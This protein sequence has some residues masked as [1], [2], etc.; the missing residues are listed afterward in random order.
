[1]KRRRAPAV[2]VHVRPLWVLAFLSGTAALLYQSLWMRSLGLV[3]GNTTDA[4]AMV[5]ATFM[6]GLA[7]GSLV[8]A[9]RPAARPLRAYA[10]VELAL[11][12]TALLTWPLLKLLPAAYAGVAW[13]L[14]LEGAADL[15]ARGLLSALVL[16]PPT[17]L[18]GA[19]VP[20][21][22]E[23]LTRAGQGL[24]TV[25]A[26]IY[27]VNTLGAALGVA[28]G[29]FLLVPAL[30]L[31]GT[32]LAA[33]LLNLTVGLAALRWSEKEPA[34]G[35]V[36]GA[37]GPPPSTARGRPLFALLAFAS[38]AFSFG[39]EVLWTRSLV[40]VIG[41]SIYAFNLVLLA[42]LAGIV[43]GTLAYERLRPRVVRPQT[44]LGL[45][46]LA[47]GGTAAAGVFVLGQLPDAYLALMRALPVRFAWHLAGGFGL[48]LAAMLPVTATVGLTFPLLLHLVE[49]DRP[50]RATG[51][52]YAWNT[53][54]A[55]VGA[56]CADLVFVRALGLQG[57]LL[58][59][60][61]LLAACGAATLLGVRGGS[62][63]PRRAAPVA[64]AAVLALAILWRP[65]D[66]LRM[67][68]GVYQ[69]GLQWREQ[70]GF[71]LSHLAADRRILFYEEGREAVIAVAERPGTGRRYL[72][73]NGKTDAG[74]GAEDVLTQKF[75]A[76][77]PLLLHPSPR[78]V[79]VVGWG[80]GATV[81]A[82]ALYPVERLEC[83]EI[84]PA[85]W[86]AAPLFSALSGGVRA[87]PR[88][89]VVF[90]DG[91][92]HLLRSAASWDVVVSEPSNPWIAGVSNLFT[93]EFY[94]VVRSRLGPGGL[95]GQWFHYYNFD[96]ADVKVE[97]HTFARAFPHVSLWV[98]PPLPADQGATLGADLLL[99]GSVE[100]HA[101]DWGRLRR[102]F[103]GGAIAE[104]LRATRVLADEAGVL[105]AWTM[106]ERGLE[107][108]VQDP[109]RFPR[110]TPLNTDDHPWIEF[111][112]PRRNVRPPAEVARLARTQYEDLAGAGE[113]MGPLRGA[114]AAGP[115]AAS[116]YRRVA[117]RHAEA[118]R[119]RRALRALER[120]VEA[121]PTSGAVWESLGG[122]YLDGGDYAR[123]ERSHRELLR[124][125]PDDVPARL[126]L[127]AV[128]ARRGRWAEARAA[129]L[130]ARRLDGAAPVDPGLLAYVESRITS[131]RP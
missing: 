106:D 127:G 110:G 118:A 51:L 43:A 68:A 10:R 40:L 7:L 67:T 120:A 73:V 105:A 102:A 62:P 12:A 13:R 44:W 130:E 35:R 122:L 50:Q 94:E 53:A 48:C 66:P 23:H 6:G 32:L 109:R 28:L 114:P 69:Y 1:M 8:A 84:E 100:P 45:L 76:H 39:M 38:G 87:D 90:R 20:L 128:L 31:T 19:T 54:G 2:E 124:L 91:R 64:A 112:A 49:T 24:R 116:L 14:A 57:S 33:A 99:V 56:L 79:L 125:R 9:R 72:S 107:R 34:R 103:A 41:S 55:L 115:E 46:F 95:F 63:W 36:A 77:V 117:D 18:L 83:V 65:W 4:V 108:Y 11:G 81:A 70:V 101:L 126:R 93:L 58:A 85:T 60:A 89:G 26:R 131:P 129:L 104:D 5:L 21:L 113:P 47:A 75:I 71:R 22:V 61:S 82:S 98:V 121:D 80:A 52:L 97:L 15:L 30:G 59:L 27:L 74:S 42:V 123:A 29:G 88:F 37:E 16:L 119:P 86:R 25:V 92:N 3:F 96:P 78:R 17:M 111:A